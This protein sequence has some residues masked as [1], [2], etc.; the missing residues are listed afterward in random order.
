MVCCAGCHE[1]VP[2]ANVWL[3]A[4]DVLTLCPGCGQSLPVEAVDEQ[5]HD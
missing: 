1:P 5:T 3:C 2:D 4:D